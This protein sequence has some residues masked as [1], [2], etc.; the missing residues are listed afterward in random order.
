MI[1]DA[2]RSLNIGDNAAIS[3]TIDQRRTNDDGANAATRWRA[4]SVSD[5]NR[6][7]VEDGGYA[8]TTD[9]PD[10][11]DSRIVTS[12]RGTQHCIP[13]DK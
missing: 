7:D 13:Q 3:I 6:S 8:G 1:N 9:A 12:W 4:S 10:Q 5:G 2:R 11:I